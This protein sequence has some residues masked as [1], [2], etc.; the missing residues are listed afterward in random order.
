M[1]FT[2]YENEL[3][4]K[5]TNELT[6]DEKV[7]HKKLKARV[8]MKTYRAK[9]LKEAKPELKIPEVEVKKINEVNIVKPLWYINLVKENKKFKINSDVYIQYRAYDESQ[10]K[11]LLKTFDDVLFK[12]FE[13]K[14]TENTKSIIISIYRGKNVEV[15][16]FKANLDNFKKELK[17]FNIYNITNTI[18]KIKE[19]FKNTNTLQTKLRPIVNLLARIDSYE[20]PYQIITNFN[21]SLKNTYI[22]KRE[23]NDDSD[24]EIEKL[25]HIMELYN[26]DK[27]DDTNDF[28][29]SSS[30]NTRDKL[31]SSFYLLMPARRLEYR[32]L[33]LIYDGYDIEK[34]SNNF[35]YIVI[36]KDDIPTEI[37]F[38]RYKTARVGGKIKKEV[39]GI[40]KYELNKYIVKYLIDYINENDIKI[41][42]MLFD[43][44]LSTFSKLIG[45]IMNN[46]FKY[47]NINA[48]TIRRISAIYNQQNPSKSIKEKK[49]TATDMAHNYTQNAL[50]NKI[51][52]K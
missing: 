2:D 24:K 52:K 19:I 23:E 45:D 25:Q 6:D 7:L 47:Q 35:N 16:K 29:E 27:L 40:Q 5:P 37:I 38:K 22:E 32:F 12:V 41:N 4:K 36:D 17:I 21:I 33:R 44:A 34:L 14:L 20:K 42:D 26:P 1:P 46:L 15:G 31:L 18:N 50:Y 11:N 28:I 39:Y 51:V 48:T 10:I 13:I 9:Q 43:I 49:K 3:L 30:L 8:Y